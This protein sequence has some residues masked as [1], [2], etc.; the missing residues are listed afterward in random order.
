MPRTAGEVLPNRKLGMMGGAAQASG[1]TFVTVNNYSGQEVRDT[2]RNEGDDEF[3]DIAIGDSIL[4]GKQDGPL[5]TVG[6]KPT[7]WER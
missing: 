6:A 3:I 2:R 5:G 1:Q 7:G 4:S